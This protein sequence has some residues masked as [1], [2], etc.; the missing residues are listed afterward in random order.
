MPLTAKAAPYCPNATAR[1]AYPPNLTALMDYC[2]NVT[3]EAPNQNLIEF[4]SHMDLITNVTALVI[5]SS[6]VTAKTA[7]LP[8][9]TAAF[10]HIFSIPNVTLSFF[11]NG[12][13]S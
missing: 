1:A 7:Y 3:A 4:F 5:N 12:F 10:V 8:S 11:P 13:H 9:V 6:N 2:S